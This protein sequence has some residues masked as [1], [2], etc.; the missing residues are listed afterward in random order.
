MK[1]SRVHPSA[2]ISS[3][4]IPCAKFVI[5]FSLR[6]HPIG[7][8]ARPRK[9]WTSCAAYWMSTKG[10]RDD[11]FR[12]WDFA[13]TDAGARVDSAA[14]HLARRGAGSAVCG[15]NGGLPKCGGA[16]CIGDR[17]AGADDGLSGD[18]LRLVAE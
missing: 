1:C 18:H 10:E 9:K 3:G 8:A 5:A 7:G 16:L 14:F 12:A 15:C 11:E 6:T 13:G 4:E 17:C 2:C